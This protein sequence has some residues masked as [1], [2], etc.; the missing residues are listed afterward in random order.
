MTI[1][2]GTDEIGMIVGNSPVIHG[3]DSTATRHAFDGQQVAA[4]GHQQVTDLQQGSWHPT[5]QEYT[6]GMFRRSFDKLASDVQIPD[7]RKADEDFFHALQLEPAI[8]V[9]FITG[10]EKIGFK[11]C[12]SS[13]FTLRDIH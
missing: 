10:P 7:L 3:L 1:R 5:A 4:T 11:D 2:S 6:E 8:R 9:V 13:F 12:I